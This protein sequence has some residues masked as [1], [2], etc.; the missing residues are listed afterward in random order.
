MTLDLRAWRIEH[1][2]TQEQV[3]AAL[4]IRPNTWARWERGDLAIRHE[5]VLRLALERIA[6]S[7]R[8]AS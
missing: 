1:G 7:R 6:R 2:Y 8:R 5:H 3:A 4:Q